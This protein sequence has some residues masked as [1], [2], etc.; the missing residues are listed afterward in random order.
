MLKNEI[1]ERNP[2]RR[3]LLQEK[4]INQGQIELSKS[5]SLP[6]FEIGYYYLGLSNQNFNGVHLGFSIPYGKIITEQISINQ[7]FYIPILK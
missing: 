2:L 5:L 1:E 7:E 4:L 6:K 3:S